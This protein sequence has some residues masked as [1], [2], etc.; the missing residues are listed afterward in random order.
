MMSYICVKY[1]GMPDMV[2]KCN[3]GSLRED[4]GTA[5][6]YHAQFGLLSC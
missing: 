4:D 3:N 1:A 5:F 2:Y 6:K